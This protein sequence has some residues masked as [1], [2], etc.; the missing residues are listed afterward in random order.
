MSTWI[1]AFAGMTAQGRQRRCRIESTRS[2]GLNFHHWQRY[3]ISP[4]GHIPSLW[5]VVLFDEE[6]ECSRL[7]I[8]VIGYSVCTNSQHDKLSDLLK[9]EPITI[10]VKTSER[11]LSTIKKLKCRSTKTAT[12]IRLVTLRCNRPLEKCSYNVDSVRCPRSFAGKKMNFL[13]NALCKSRCQ[14]IY[15]SQ[16]LIPL[17]Q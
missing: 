14:E 11:E 12:Y 10:A 2:G 5:V 15:T 6:I 4:R 8:R 13:P 9:C 17:T 3:R 1:P 16:D 7:D